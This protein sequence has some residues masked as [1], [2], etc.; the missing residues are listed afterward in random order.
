METLRGD[1]VPS[2]VILSDFLTSPEGFHY[3]IKAKA[4]PWLHF[5]QGQEHMID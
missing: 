3:Y 5:R 2:Q 1:K 4:L